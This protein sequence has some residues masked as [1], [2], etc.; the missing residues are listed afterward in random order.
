MS[1]ALELK[2]FP[3]YGARLIE[4]SAGTGKTFTIS[5][6]VLRLLLGDDE[7]RTPLP[8][9]AILVV[10][11][12]EAATAELRGR[13]RGRI[14]QARLDFLRSFSDD[15]LT[16]HLIERSAD[17]LADAERLLVAEQNMDQASVFT[18]HG[19]CQRM[20]KEHAFESGIPFESEFINAEYQ[21]RLRA[22]EDCWREMFY[23]CSKALVNRIMTFWRD[24]SSLLNS[25]MGV[26]AQPQLNLQLDG[27]DI[28]T[29]FS[30]YFNRR[31][32]AIATFKTRW[33]HEFDGFL[34]ALESCD[35]DKRSY[36]KRN[37]P[38]WLDEIHLFAQSET[39]DEVLPSNLYR[40][41][42]EILSQKT[43]S[44]PVPSHPLI[45]A[46]DQLVT[47]AVDLQALIL[48]QIIMKVRQRFSLL[49]EAQQQ[50]GFDDL[51]TILANALG[52]NYDGPLAQ[53]I[54]ARYPVAMIDEF[55][56]TD[57]QQY[58][59]F[60]T[61]YSTQAPEETGLF[62]IGDPKQAI[63][64]FRGADIFTYMQARSQVTS[65]YTLPV[66]YRSSGSMVKAVNG[67]FEFHENPFIYREAIE[68]QPVQS[69]PHNQTSL[70]LKLNGC[71]QK[72]LMF[73]VADTGEATLNNQQYQ[74]LQARDCACAIRQWLTQGQLDEGERGSRP[75]E[76]A[77]IAALVRT[78]REGALLA[79]AF[80]QLAIPYVLR[81]SRDSVFASE[82]GYQLYLQ[83]AAALQPNHDR[84]LRAA[85]AAPLL[86]FSIA[87][88]EALNEN[89]L[90]WQDWVECYS[91]Y[92]RI[93]H[94]RGILPMLYRWLEHS[95][96][97]E[98]LLVDRQGERQL[99][100]LL[101]LGELLQTQSSQ[102]DSPMALL[103]WFAQQL[104]AGKSESDDA[105][106][107][108]ESDAKRVQ[109]VTIH[110]SKGL[111]YP[112]VALPFILTYRAAKEA[113]YHQDGQLT[114]ALQG[115]DEVKALADQERLAEDLRLLYV[116]LTRAKYHCLIGVGPVT[117]R[118]NKKGLTHI[119][120]S[121]L[122][123]LLQRAQKGNKEA[124]YQALNL[125]SEHPD[126]GFA[127]VV[128]HWGDPLNTL[129]SD[130]LAL[131]NRTV[132]RRLV[133][134]WWL[135]S[136][137][138]LSR[139]QGGSPDAS[140]ELAY[141]DT[142]IVNE[143]DESDEQLDIFH[144]PKGPQAGTFLHSMFEEIDFQA[145]EDEVALGLSDLITRGGYD[146]KWLAVLSQLRA[147]VLDV[148]LDDEG[149]VAPYHLRAIASGQRLTEME[150]VMP[151]ARITANEV[152]QFIR[153]YDSLSEQA[154][155][156]SFQQVEGMLKGF[157]DLVFCVD[158]R[159]Y[160][161]DYKS[162][163]LGDTADDYSVD[164]MEKAM[165]EHRYDFQYQIYA[166][167][168]HRLLKS[169]LLDYDYAHHF[170]GVYYLFLRGI[171]TASM[172]GI[173]FTRPSEEFLTH[174]DAI[175]QG[176]VDD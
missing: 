74:Q 65:H 2:T 176:H 37:L 7:K 63:Y 51:L 167:A 116:A 136:Y 142:A 140:M 34:E 153:E 173:Y 95:Q 94:K 12:T 59:I 171:T 46:V 23:P 15:F 175:L 18:I 112:V 10:T 80:D 129:T 88:L 146:D 163:Y 137:S 138:A 97:A 141:L 82:E 17:I 147:N 172:T 36:N 134:D 103:R 104:L 102:L 76:P 160:V 92:R 13:I 148:S 170:G 105:Q 73:K 108:L 11:F 132:V 98:R 78:N 121:A 168:L 135:T 119:D 99:T 39:H 114:L 118:A 79:N 166:L 57:P 124:L 169:R 1:E 85:L 154:M 127:P 155:P 16:Q 86:G 162:N 122:G 159:Y 41:S 158:G 128:T 71:V 3:L 150:F 50:L 14:H 161:A 66:N 6:L 58:Q 100:N 26:L 115:S 93:W 72:A 165:I 139:Q 35:L 89:E 77:D 164:A 143:K 70:G 9:E 30:A 8:I 54:R 19:F 123:F 149:R 156:L 145:S 84:L 111:E 174:F 28:A 157:I 27:I 125:L 60:S 52:H 130:D 62:L 48:A 120:Q 69:A 152:N 43:K 91:D 113:L 53:S 29:D 38:K 133:Q 131:S 96:I 20:L 47:E 107:R 144:F 106:I 55:Q 45:D 110:K 31:I 21:L 151:M 81:A 49:K 101:H 4:A 24:P 33:V 126:I 56:D 83:M 22:V 75:V 87:E 32:E 40:F 68:F 109:I 42:H 64:G 61:I 5:A 117:T 25:L 44:G 90:I 67:L